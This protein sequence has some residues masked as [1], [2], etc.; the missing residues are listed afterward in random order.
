MRNERRTADSG[1]Q[2]AVI[3]F[4]ADPSSYPG[5][6]QV[7]RLETHGNLVF[8]AGEDAWKIKRAVSFPYMDFSTLEKRR[9]ACEREV[10]VNRRFAPDLY[11][12]C[13]PIV[14]TGK[15][16]FAFGG[17]GDIVDWAVHMRRFDQAALLSS[18]AAA[19]GID[20][21]LAKAMADAVYDSHRGAPSV[22]TV[23]G[24]AQIAD[25]VGSICGSLARSDAFA[26]QDTDRLSPH[27][28][29]QL[30]RAS[31][32]LDRRADSG[33]VRR[34]HGDLHLAN[35]VLWHGRPTLF[36]AIE[37]D[38]KIAT[39]DTLYDLAFLLMDLRRYGQARA[40]NVV[41]NRYLW[42]S[43]NDLDLTGL[44]ALPLFIGLRAGVRAMVTVDRATQEDR[45]V[46]EQDRELSRAYLR[47]ALQYFAPS[48]PQLIA[49]GGLS[50]TGKSTLAAALAPDLDPAPGAVHLRS[51]LERK[52]MFGVAETVRLPAEA[53]SAEASRSV[54]DRL[55]RKARLVLAA[56]QSVVVDAV[57]ARPDERSAIEGVASD[58]KVP[59]R[60]LWLTAAGD[61]L[62]ARVAARHNDA[63]DA[64]PEFVARQL[65]WDTGALSPAWTTL[66]AS[67]GPDETLRRT[68][69]MLGL[70]PTG[71]NRQDRDREAP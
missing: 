37:F 38:E 23:S 20:A 21:D 35:I 62:T 19:D 22:T 55:C 14:R 70:D 54:Y 65:T 46:A 45:H 50:G 39:I 11:F 9:V 53:Y 25:L 5:V 71:R 16:T 7:D 26:S 48:P 64:T 30:A 28:H 15:G 18:I 67:A 12:G 57:H 58:L 24:S 29:E 27:A 47:A 51:D 66:D 49:V 1:D 59:F 32:T 52:T 10:E 13:V 31:A 2:A 56:G 61:E 42:R 43:Q 68:M 41:L 69:A 60:G 63:S 8:L 34:C 33:C 6:S 44:Q 3:A 40:A 36:D 17:D 4:L